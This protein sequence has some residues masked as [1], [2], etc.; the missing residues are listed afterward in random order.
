M[1]L[2]LLIVGAECTAFRR[3]P[4]DITRAQIQINPQLLETHELRELF[5]R[6]HAA[7]FIQCRTWLQKIPY[8]VKIKGDTVD[9][10]A[11]WD[12]YRYF[13]YFPDAVG[14]VL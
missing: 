1:L 9:S 6:V 4:L 5:H 11:W 7:R 8:H 3:L 2:S 10:G 14:M 12:L 13:F